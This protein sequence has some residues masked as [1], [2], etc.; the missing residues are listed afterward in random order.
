MNVKVRSIAVVLL[1][2]S[3]P[4]FSQPRAQRGRSRQSAQAAS[5]D[6]PNPDPAAALQ[7]LERELPPLDPLPPPAE[8]PPAAGPV[9]TLPEALAQTR[10]QSPDLTIARERVVQAQNTVS[11]AWATLKPTLTA[12]GQ[13]TR[14][15]TSADI[16]LPGGTTFSTQRLNSFTGNLTGAITIFNGRAFP[17]IA[18]A[19]DQVEVAALSES[20][21][22]R[23]LLLNVAAL[24]LTGV[25]QREL[26]TAAFHHAA[27]VR[28]L[29]LQSQARYEAGVLQRSAA[30]RARL[31]VVN[32]DEEARRQQFAYA[33]T[34]SSL[35]ALLDRHDIAFELAAPRE[36]PP[37]LRGAFPE[38]LERALRDRPEMAAAR[39]NQEIARRLSTDAWAQFLPTLSLNGQE[40]YNNAAGFSNQTLTW[41]VSLALSVPLYDGGYRYVALR[42]A[43]SQQ[44]Q[45]AAQTRGQGIRIEDELRRGQLDLDA[46]RA[47]VAEGEQALRFARENERLIRAQ[48]EAGTATQVE[49]SD[50]ESALFSSEANLVQQRSSVQ[51]SS[52]R[53]MRALGAFDP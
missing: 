49:V 3:G 40:R 1:F 33:S 39:I 6:V 52:L 2:A 12:N 13:Y 53:L 27:S 45:A 8:E 18:S 32:A 28:G 20:Q 23:E 14:N 51:L 29:A 24:Y 50:A 4:A 7:P 31:D 46:A 26:A 19:Y 5:P 35:A 47:L 9:L 34:R 30:V 17:A 37:E 48:F 38:L 10:S 41:A 25:S 11:R 16:T 15:S 22:R 42:E 44:R 21:T 43:A 36:P